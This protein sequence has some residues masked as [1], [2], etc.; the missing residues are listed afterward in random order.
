MKRRKKDNININKLILLSF[1]KRKI[2]DRV[3][4]DKND[5]NIRKK[6]EIVD[7]QRSIE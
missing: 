4:I 6:W 3:I 7:G 1:S 2:I 5:K